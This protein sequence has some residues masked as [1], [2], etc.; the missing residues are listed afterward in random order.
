MAIIYL[1]IETTGLDYIRNRI[2]TIQLKENYQ[3]IEIFKIWESDE[4]SILENFVNRLTGIQS[5][6]KF[7]ICVGFNIMRFD[8]PFLISRCNHFGIRTPNDLIQ[9]F[10]R[11]LAHCDLLQIFLPFNNWKYKGLTW[12]YVLDQYGYQTK[13]GSGEQIPIWYKEG[14]Y[15]KI[16]SYIESEFPPMEDIYWKLRK[17]NFHKSM[18]EGG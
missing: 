5:N 13:A 7:T 18:D 1:D 2:I 11:N 12:D 10:Y 3:Q 4:K 15:D 16:I 17:S 8:I 6:E 9:I 14:K